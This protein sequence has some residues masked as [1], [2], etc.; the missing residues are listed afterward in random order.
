M[1]AG[2]ALYIGDKADSLAKGVILA[3]EILDSGDA[4]KAMERYIKASN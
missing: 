2:A 4:Y 3:E 1:N